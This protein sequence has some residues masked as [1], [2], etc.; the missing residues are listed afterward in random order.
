MNRFSCASERIKLCWLERLTRKTQSLLLA[1]YENYVPTSPPPLVADDEQPSVSE[2]Q[3]E[4]DTLGLCRHEGCTRPAAVRQAYLCETHYY[5]ASREN[6]RVYFRNL[7]TLQPVF[8][9]SHTLSLPVTASPELKRYTQ[10]L[11]S[12]AASLLFQPASLS[13]VTIRQ[14]IYSS[15]HY[16][17]PKYGIAVTA[18]FSLLTLAEVLNSLLIPYVNNADEGTPP[19]KALNSASWCHCRLRRDSYT[20]ASVP[21]LHTCSLCRC[22]TL[23]HCLR[24]AVLP[25]LARE[26]TLTETHCSSCLNPHHLSA[27]DPSSSQLTCAGCCLAA[28]FDL[29]QNTSAADQFYAPP[30]HSIRVPRDTARLLV[31]LTENISGSKRSRGFFSGL[32]ERSTSPSRWVTIEA[33]THPQGTE[34]TDPSPD[35]INAPLLQYLLSTPLDASFLDQVRAPCI[36]PLL[37]LWLD[38]KSVKLRQM[39]HGTSFSSGSLPRLI[40][41]A[42]SESEGLHEPN[43]CFYIHLGLATQIHPILLATAF[44]LRAALLWDQ[45]CPDPCRRTDIHPALIPGQQ[46]HADMLEH[47]WPIEL[48]SFCIVIIRGSLTKPHFERF[49]PAYCQPVDFRTSLQPPHNLPPLRVHLRLHNNHFTLLLPEVGSPLDQYI[50]DLVDAYDDLSAYPPVIDYYA[51][52]P[53][54]SLSETDWSVSNTIAKLLEN[55]SGDATS[56]TASQQGSSAALPAHSHI[57]IAGTLP[58]ATGASDFDT[59]ELLSRDA[60]TLLLINLQPPHLAPPSALASPPPTVQSS[61][62]SSRPVLSSISAGRQLRRRKHHRKQRARSAHAT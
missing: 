13:L 3:A 27:V 28:F 2:M 10:A 55:E 34:S 51:Q 62:A 54:D 7:L 52:L 17:N 22:L 45:P 8:R 43:R 9:A 38:G 29:V 46:V 50:Q 49:W 6:V 33:S 19:S 42:L 21:V 5:G 30:L 14:K 47:I 58:E 57:D 37:T 1:F 26:P 60:D 44:R 40:S 18:T 31:P 25:Q 56:P 16:R 20:G 59:S 39:D 32:R 4:P 23:R 11:S 41:P 12:S 24:E 61:S 35:L 36:T 15:L 53:I 48:N